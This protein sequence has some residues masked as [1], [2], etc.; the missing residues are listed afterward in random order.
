MFRKIFKPTSPIVLASASPRRRELLQQV[1]IPVSVVPSGV[2]ETEREGESPAEHVERLS[3]EKAFE[4]AARADV[5][6]RWFLGSDTIVVLDGRIL[7]KPC[8][9]G[10]A[11]IMLLDLS[12][13]SHRVWSGYAIFDRQT[14][15]TSCGSIATSVHFRKL[16]EAEVAGYIASGEP[17]DKA[18][19][20]AIQGLGAFMVRGIEGSYSN[21]VGLPLCEVVE[22]LLRLEAIRPLEG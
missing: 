6:G 2:E 4:V 7:G 1:G 10:E 8:D 21:V 22:A 20:Y 3:R 17:M 18:G 12:G 15:D 13:R 14:G 9:A 11:R 5:P 16:T 19:A